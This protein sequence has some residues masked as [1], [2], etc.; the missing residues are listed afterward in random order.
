MK[1]TFQ[2]YETVD[3]QKVLQTSVSSRG[4]SDDLETRLQDLHDRLE[5]LDENVSLVWLKGKPHTFDAVLDLRVKIEAVRWMLRV[6]KH[7]EN[8][9][10][11]KVFLTVGNSLNDLEQAFESQ[12]QIHEQ[13]VCLKH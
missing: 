8:S 7:L 5:G 1:G 10:R 2:I 4:T 6:A 11:E 9:A 3:I 12:A 13:A